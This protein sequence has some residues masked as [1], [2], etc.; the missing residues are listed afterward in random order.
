MTD[1]EKLQ[2]HEPVTFK[3]CDGIEM[4]I[5]TDSYGLSVKVAGYKEV[6]LIDVNAERAKVLLH[7]D[8]A[9]YQGPFL[10]MITGEWDLTEE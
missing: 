5:R 8:G 10:E 9:D 1:N 7:E 3:T 4:T 2:D 6:V